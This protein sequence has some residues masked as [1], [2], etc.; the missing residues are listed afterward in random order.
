MSGGA[1]KGVINPI[2]EEVD[3]PEVLHPI[4][5]LCEPIR[6]FTGFTAAAVQLYSFGNLV[7]ITNAAGAGTQST[8]LCAF[9]RGIWDINLILGHVV[10]GAT[11]GFGI[12]SQINAIDPAGVATSIIVLPGFNLINQPMVIIQR[13]LI[14]FADAGWTLRVDTP[15]PITA[16]SV[17]NVLGQVY[18]C[19]Q[20]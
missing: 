7:Q 11:H 9:A 14:H 8:A 2:A 20:L 16:L 10:T 15:D 6:Q 3:I 19:R 4:L 12:A 17:S 5:T 1:Q 18:A 13:F